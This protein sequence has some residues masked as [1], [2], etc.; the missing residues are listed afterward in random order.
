V[1][2]LAALTVTTFG[3]TRLVALSG[4][5]DVSN[6]ASLEDRV[7]RSISSAGSVVVDLTR[8]TFIDSAG[9]RLLDHLVAADPPGGIRVVVSAGGVR[10]TLRL[11]GF[12]PDL[13]ADTLED[14][15][16]DLG[17]EPPRG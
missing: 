12:R 9:V 1:S 4:E 10:T 11:C 17:T 5:I 2:D 15:L 13:L 16:R 6:A 14:A 7:L 8:L 3:T